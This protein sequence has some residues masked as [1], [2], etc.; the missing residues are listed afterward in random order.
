MADFQHQFENLF[1]LMTENPISE[2]TAQ[3]VTYELMLA[4]YR[5]R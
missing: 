3:I 4:S 5:I 2:A 1:L